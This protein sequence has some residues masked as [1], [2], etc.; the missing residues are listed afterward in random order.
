[1]PRKSPAP[2]VKTKASY[3][4]GDL[5]EQLVRAAH[6]LIER[7]GAAS[8]RV[9]DACRLAG[10]STAAPYRHFSDREA[11]LEAVA[12]SAFASLGRTMERRVAEQVAAGLDAITAIGLAYVDFARASPEVFRLMFSCRSRE[13]EESLDAHERGGDAYGVLIREVAAHL[14]REPD[15][16]AVLQTAL[17]LWTMVHGL[18]SL[19]IDEQLD[20]ARLDIDVEGMLRAG[21]GKLLEAFVD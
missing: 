8:F 19:L 20:V 14:G 3:H 7:D 21:G 11:I 4:H 1:M 13:N 6:R 2:R 15:D 12:A 9:A 18:S 5:R 17:A 16:E 10:V